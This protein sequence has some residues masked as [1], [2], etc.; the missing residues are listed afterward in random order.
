VK[1]NKIVAKDIYTELGVSL[2]EFKDRAATIGIEV[3]VWN[4]AIAEED[5][6]RLKGL[7]KTSSLAA[8]L[9][10]PAGDVATAAAQLGVN[11]SDPTTVGPEV[12]G[13]IRSR[14]GALKLAETLSA[15]VGLVAEIAALKGIPTAEPDRLTEPQLH[16][17][18]LGI[19][20]AKLAA[21][22]GVKL[23]TVFKTSDTLDINVAD[24]AA[25]SEEDRARI[26]ACDDAV[27]LSTELKIS[28][29]DLRRLGSKIGI[30]I[31]RVGFKG[32]TKPEI[33]LLRAQYRTQFGGANTNVLV[34]ASKVEQ[35][36][37]AAPTGNKAE[38]PP[39]PPRAPGQPQQQ[40]SQQQQSGGGRPGQQAGQQQ[41]QGNQQ[42]RPGPG[43][44]GGPGSQVS[45]PPGATGRRRF[46]VKDT[47]YGSQRGT[48]GAPGA[49]RGG[50]TGPQRP[51]AAPAGPV[52]VEMPVNL[53]A[54]SEALGVKVNDI[55]AAL[56]K[57]GMM[58]RINDA[59]SAEMIENISVMLEREI[60][61]KA[62]KSAEELITAELDSYDEVPGDL[63]HRAPVVT[64]MGHVD[65]GKTSLLDAINRMDRAAGEA[66]GI[67]QHIGAFRVEVDREGSQRPMQVTFIDTPG[68]EAFTAMRARGAQATDVAVIVVAAD[69]GV[70]PQTEEAIA[71]ARAAGVEIVV[72]INKVDKRDANVART[73]QML[74][75]QNLMSPDWGGSTEIVEVSA[76][77]GKGIPQL[78]A[79]LSDLTDVLELK[80]NPD[81][82]A[83]GVVLEAH[84][85]EGRG[86]VATV[87]V[88]DG[89]LHKGQAIVAGTGYGRVRAMYD[90]RGQE[91]KDAGPAWPVE[92]T[93]LSE[94]PEAGAKFHG[95]LDYKK[96]QQIAQKVALQEKEIRRAKA[97]KPLT[98]EAWSQERK[99]SQTNDLL[100]VLKTDV[101]GTEE[102]IK[103]EL[104]KFKHEEVGIRIIHSAVGT[105]STN[106][107]HLAAASGA[108]VIGFNCGVQPT[109]REL[110]D[111]HNVQIREYEVIY[112]LLE[113]IHD[114]LSGMLKPEEV[115]VEQGVIEV[116]KLFKASK[117]GVIAGCFVTEG[118]VTRNSRVRVIRDGKELYDGPIESLK[119]FQDE[120]KEVREG[121]E[122]GIVLR[123]FT[124]LREGDTMRPYAIETRERTL[125]A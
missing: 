37:Y 58:I 47:S 87:L 104:G 55:M 107:V 6:D 28:F 100:L 118:L 98:L 21:E 60:I 3:K 18:A 120:V 93:G 69:D 43:Q 61:V 77:T 49:G 123:R 52:T 72:A 5:V 54:L 85:D 14:V 124:E 121:F 13:N 80:A 59:L 115:E 16:K 45:G 84:R 57:E 106:D 68:H 29:Q 102:T 74:A 113:D 92:V 33:L 91:L 50:P 99:Q 110:A 19:G 27:T 31:G 20:A 44:P 36:K 40:Q 89:T 7:F 76:V 39:P 41:P 38:P 101:Q 56:M 97:A 81:K 79:T 2:T 95:V 8:E 119:R 67:T 30:E 35:P 32:L 66:G 114:A 42:R 11:I 53:R 25:V 96:A 23:D 24:P 71:H 88:Q 125:N 117:L 15:D 63:K 1:K 51:D 46:E 94:M 34:E 111:N 109:A 86:I 70:M 48:R 112:K 26:K 12:R 82:P 105:I 108:I 73:R 122:C 65:H 78:I 116:R 62:P 83:V 10:L 75:S 103:S 64:I 4:T 90:S 9:E 17:L 22:L